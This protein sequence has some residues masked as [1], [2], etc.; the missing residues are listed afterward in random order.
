[1]A[2]RKGRRASAHTR[3]LSGMNEAVDTNDKMLRPDVV[4]R[5]ASG[6]DELEACV[7][8]QV[9]TWGYD[10]AD[11]VPRRLFSLALRIGG[12]VLVALKRDRL[13][14]FLL[15][16]PGY[17]NGR[18]YL[19]SHML[20]VVPEMR[21]V[22]LG[23]RLKLAQRTDALARGIELIEWTFDPL[24]AKNAY[25][26][27]NKLGALA[28]RY[29]HDFY[30]PTSSPLGSGLPTDRLYAEWWLRSRRVEQTLAGGLPAFPVEQRVTVPGALTAW[31]ASVQGRVLARTLQSTN[32]QAL[33]SAFAR[34]LSAFAFERSADGGG[35]YLLGRWDEPFL[36]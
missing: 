34:G 14:G 17:R 8:L 2:A 7:Q 32:A 31:K 27:L 36:L 20:A 29:A 16:L 12:Q 26:N 15:A 23:R 30:G 33:Q 19:H 9:A 22:G 35:S 28:R 13:V 24:V 21:N 5:S 10:A 6:L 11:I 3:S 1:M 25:L 18:G 4:I